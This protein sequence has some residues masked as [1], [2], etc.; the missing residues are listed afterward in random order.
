[1]KSLFYLLLL[2]LPTLGLSTIIIPPENMA[3]LAHD[4]DAIVYGTITDHI[5]GNTY[6]NKFDI[7]SVIK[8]IEK[9]VQSINIEEYGSKIDEW[10]NTV[11]GDT[12]YIIGRKYLLFLF[13]KEN[14]NYRAQLMA[15]GVFIQQEV[16]GKNVFLH[17]KSVK[18]ILLKE[19]MN[20]INL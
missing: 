11:I 6:L 2:L 13:K 20:Q 4:S 5:D 9:N 12:D 14:G 16:E 18:E 3:Q 19:F 10:T 7:I 8:G 1:M 17:E 15:L